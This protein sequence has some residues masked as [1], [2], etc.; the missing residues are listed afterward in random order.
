[1]G[2]FCGVAETNLW[3]SGNREKPPRRQKNDAPP[4]RD[5]FRAYLVEARQRNGGYLAEQS[6]VL[7]A[8][9]NETF[10]NLVWVEL[11]DNVIAAFDVACAD[12][13]S[14]HDALLRQWDEAQ[15]R[16]QANALHWQLLTRRNITVIE[17]LADR[18]FLPR[19]GF[20]IG[21]LKLRVDVEENDRNNSDQSRI[22]EEDQFRLERPGLLALREYVPGSRI[23]A[24]GKMVTSRGI[25]KHWTGAEISDVPIGVRGQYTT[26]TTDHLYYWGAD[27]NGR[28]CP[29]CGAPAKRSPSQY[30]LP[31]YGF[32]SA[33]WD[34]PKWSVGGPEFVGET[35][36]VPSSFTFTVNSATH[37]DNLGGVDGLSAS[38]REDGELLVYNEGANKNGFAI[39]LSC[40]YSESEPKNAT[41]SR[42]PQGLRTHTPLRARRRNGQWI[43]RSCGGGNQVPPVL[44]NQTFAARETTDVLLLDFSG[45]LDPAQQDDIALI[46]TLGY[47]LHRAAAESLQLDGRELGVTTMPTG[48]HSRGVLLYDNVP[49]GAGHVR[50]LV[51]IG[52]EWLERARQVLFVDDAHHRRCQSACLDCVLSFQTQNAM[53]QGLLI[54]PQALSVL[55]GLLGY[56]P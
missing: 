41:D 52:R 20:P 3:A 22:H 12:W 24:G 32:R 13:Q 9:T 46:T 42:L 17:T 18:Q 31:Q 28:E 48:A 45:C 7:R 34:P 54:R 50:E 4:P 8:N 15:Q 49:G 37:Y 55:S 19:Y 51:E 23:L 29:F 16:N 36:T 14:D 35:T 11:L 56:T 40:G 25:L 47:A 39:C 2:W 10:E 21:V 6:D 1:M 27:S 44:R 38:Y 33:T 43:P 5:K 26:C 30:L 53:I